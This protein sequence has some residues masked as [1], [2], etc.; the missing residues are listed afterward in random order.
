MTQKFY[1]LVPTV[2]TK[3]VQ[4]TCLCKRVYIAALFVKMKNSGDQPKYLCIDERL[5]KL[6]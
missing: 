6:G 3:P 4:I 5:S 2:E 1:F